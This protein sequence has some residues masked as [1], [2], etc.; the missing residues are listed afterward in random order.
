MAKIEIK[1]DKIMPFGGIFSVIHEFAPIE[2]LIDSELGLRV[3]T[4]GYQYS[5]IM[6]TMMCN[7]LCGGDRMEDIKIFQPSKVSKLIFY[8]SYAFAWS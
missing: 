8:S 5:E 4:F 1:S 2:R 7:Y 6:R 3:K